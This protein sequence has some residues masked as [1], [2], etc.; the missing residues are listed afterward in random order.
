[1]RNSGQALL[2]LLIQQEGAKASSRY[3]CL[4][5]GGSWS[6][7]WDEGGGGLVGWAGELA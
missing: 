1:M 2:G 5:N 4:E 6:L 3:S 7:K